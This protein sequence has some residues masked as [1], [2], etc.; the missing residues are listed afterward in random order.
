[1]VNINFIY[2]LQNYNNQKLITIIIFYFLS[3]F[4]IFF[5]SFFIMLLG[6][7]TFYAFGQIC[8]NLLDFLS[9]IRCKKQNLAR[10]TTPSHKKNLES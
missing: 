9:P 2:K 5:P 1:M 10:N 8:K 3:Y 7:Y 4:F 6:K